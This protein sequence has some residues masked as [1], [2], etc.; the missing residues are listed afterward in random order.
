[1]NGLNLLKNIKI[2]RVLAAQ[3]D[4]QDT[5]SSDI[6]DMSGFDGI[7]FIAKF[8]DVDNTSVLT[9]QAQQNTIDSTVGMATLSG[10]STYTAA[11]TD[12]DNDLLVLDIYRPRERYLRAQVV[13]A[14]AN[15]TV[16]GVIAIQYNKIGETPITQPATV[17][18]SD[19]LI[20]PAEA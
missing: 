15:A 13:A 6:L 8:D 18:D 9:L 12:A 11:A 2:T 10:S 7:M 16:S 20:S 4:G 3:A 14:T 1:M 17:L 5:W 19:T